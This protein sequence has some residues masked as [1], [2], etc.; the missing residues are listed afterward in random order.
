VA[1][2][3]STA[4]RVGPKPDDGAPLARKRHHFLPRFLLRGFDTGFSARVPW[5]YQYRSSAEPQHVPVT[6]VAVAKGRVP[7]LRIAAAV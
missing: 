7:R 5:V 3:G 4:P 2:R 6:H 1:A